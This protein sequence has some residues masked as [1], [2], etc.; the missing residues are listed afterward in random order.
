MRWNE[1]MIQPKEEP[2]K[3]ESKEPRVLAGN[4]DYDYLSLSKGKSLPGKG[5]NS[6]GGS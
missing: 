3:E 2:K 1:D 6:F 5:G 4:K